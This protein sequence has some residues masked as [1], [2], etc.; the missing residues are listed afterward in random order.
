MSASPP[1]P[2][3]AG[4]DP[5]AIRRGLAEL[6]GG[7]WH[8]IDLHGTPTKPAP[9]ASEAPDHPRGKWH[10]L[11]PGL[12]EV[13]GLSVLDVGCSEGFFA[14][15]LK[16]LGAARVVGVD[17]DPLRVRRA[18]FAAGVLGLDVDYVHAGVANLEPLGRFDLVLALGLL[19]HVRSP[20]DALQALAGATASGG[21]LVVETAVLRES[22]RARLAR[23]ICPDLRK[24]ARFLDPGDLGFDASNTWLP[25][26]ACLGA[27]LRRVG[28]DRVDELPYRPARALVRC[29]RSGA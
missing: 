10:A 12:P 27:M 22:R 14:L 17:P 8:N 5:D 4:T 21:T 16:R 29:T 28:F 9:L 15:E 19:Y 1:T 26:R 7:W 3:D 24:V 6:G 13:R 11:R 18:R 25:D 23:W 20:W 2:P